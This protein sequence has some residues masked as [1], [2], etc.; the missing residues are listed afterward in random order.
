MTE[1]GSG[2]LLHVRE[3]C[4]DDGRG[5]E[6]FVSLEVVPKPASLFRV[7]RPKAMTSSTVGREPSMVK[8][9]AQKPS[10]RRLIIRLLNYK[11]KQN[12]SER[13]LCVRSEGN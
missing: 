5:H 3:T 13:L 6:T 9:R 11:T 4:P 8:F 12:R 1:R 10:R 7:R 2:G